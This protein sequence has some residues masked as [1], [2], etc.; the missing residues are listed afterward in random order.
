MENFG[1]DFAESQAENTPF[2][3][4]GERRLKTEFVKSYKPTALSLEG[5]PYPLFQELQSKRILSKTVESGLLGALEDLGLSLSDIEKLL[6]PIEKA[7]LLGTA[8]KNLPIIT[9]L[10]GYGL[11]EPGPVVIPLLAT[12]LKLPP[13][14]YTATFA[15]AAGAEGLIVATGA[16]DFAAAGLVLVPVA[17]V[18]GVFAA[19]P[20]ALE[21]IS[22]LPPP[23]R[24]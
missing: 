8:A 23:S 24:Q 20:A 22:R 6:I 15:A 2:A 11:V 13:V 17:L 12:L 1:L 9:I 19:L 5:Q 16:D 21:S 10:L 3:I 7:G 4:L 18:S 14:L